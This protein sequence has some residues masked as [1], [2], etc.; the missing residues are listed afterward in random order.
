MD[1][2]EMAQDEIFAGP[3]SESIPDSTSSFLH[4]RQRADSSASFTYYDNDEAYNHDDGTAVLDE[5]DVEDDEEV[6]TDLEAG[7]L[8]P[9]HRSSTGDSR[10]SVRDRLLRSDSMRSQ[11]NRQ[12][13]GHNI[14]QKIYIA[15]EDLTIVV[16]GF[17]TSLLGQALYMTL[18]IFTLGLAYLLFR[19]LPRWKVKVVGVQVP[20]KTCAWVV[21][22]VSDR[23]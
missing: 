7:T 1:D 13:Q 14:T 21:I 22:E 2:V 10:S 8:L 5:D 23:H 4:R 16:A 15:A 11:S 19:W 9:M 12:S 20:L 6:S 3:V 18:C 17:R